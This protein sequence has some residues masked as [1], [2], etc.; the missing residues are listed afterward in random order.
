M[1]ITAVQLLVGGPW[2]DD[3]SAG[4]NVVYLASPDKRRQ[5][6]HAVL[7]A[8]GADV[9]Q[10]G[11]ARVGL[12]LP[13]GRLTIELD[14]AGWSVRD[15]S[16][17]DCTTEYAEKVRAWLPPD[18]VA[19]V[20]VPRLGDPQALHE[21]THKVCGAALAEEQRRKWEALLAELEL[22]EPLPGYA[23]E[24]A[25]LKEQEAELA[26][27]LPQGAEG[28]SGNSDYNALQEKRILAQCLIRVLEKRVARAATADEAKRWQQRLDRWKSRHQK[29]QA[30]LALL[31]GTAAGAANSGC[32]RADERFAR[33]DAI[34][35][36]LAELHQQER[37]QLEYW[38]ERLRSLIHCRP[39]SPLLAD[40]SQRLREL[41]GG[42]FTGVATVR[43]GRE[44]LVEQPGGK[45]V[46]C[47]VLSRA[48]R[49]Q[50][51]LA[52]CLA[53]LAAASRAGHRLPL[54]IN[55][56]VRHIPPARVRSTVELLRA[57]GR[58]C[59]QVVLLTSQPHVA[60]LCRSLGV[61]VHNY[62]VSVES[63]SRPGARDAQAVP[64]S[65]EEVW[66][67]TTRSSGW[68][69]ARAEAQ[70]SVDLPSPPGTTRQ[71]APVP[72]TFNGTRQPLPGATA[73][74]RCDQEHRHELSDSGCF[75]RLSDPV[76]RLT[77]LPANFVGLLQKATIYTVGAFL[78]EEPAA[79]ASRMG[80]RCEPDE[81]V[82]IWQAQARLL[83]EVPRL[84]PY[85]AQIL[86]AC[87]ITTGEQLADIQP[88]EL[89]RLVH[90]FLST[91]EGA[92]LARTG[93]NEEIQR[94]TQWLRHMRQVL[95]ANART[96]A[97]Q[98]VTDSSDNLAEHVE[99][100]KTIHKCGEAATTDASADGDV[101]AG[102]PS[103]L[104]PIHSAVDDGSDGDG[105]SLQPEAQA[106]PTDP[107][108]RGFPVGEIPGVTGPVAKRLA[109]LGIRTL[110]ELLKW[111]A[112]SVCQQLR[113]KR[114]T[115]DVVEQWRQMAQ[116]VEAVPSL[117]PYEAYLLVLS[118]VL[119]VDQLRT[120]DAQTLFLRVQRVARSSTGRR[121]LGDHPPPTV[122]EVVRWVSI[123]RQRHR[124]Q[125]A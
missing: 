83:A 40:A 12:S 75:L 53:A 1:Q 119:H 26:A 115:V 122:E 32:A 17:I 71:A 6:T 68:D 79:L 89:Y 15:A 85:D 47:D 51:H 34:R 94:L 13:W 2:I 77:W 92:R 67:Q 87:G 107:E 16:G 39:S 86:V 54:V 64:V 74:S 50:V 98:Q 100:A 52:V 96:A 18:V 42:E 41:S 78:R 69:F 14:G 27:A 59:G 60:T 72:A 112:E 124:N 36:R 116:L 56:A 99:P 90:T 102:E 62:A 110:A 80:G 120:A 11:A 106:S 109:E 35:R 37:Q 76:G 61:T 43:L 103:T 95:P 73:A 8:L 3:F 105:A 48:E 84:R 111:D 29:I 31:D 113:R 44:T 101:A 88:P 114:I 91:P 28:A 25:A 33:L 108:Q 104:V 21:T 65:V 9:E 23:E 117:R 81:Q 121:L 30:R 38:L 24:L 45:R 46:S 22:A 58:L 123:A 4:L 5:I 82:R 97:P 66:K 93:T 10:V 20:C 63:L 49:V 55:D 7:A 125:A 118:G 57:H 70:P 19:S